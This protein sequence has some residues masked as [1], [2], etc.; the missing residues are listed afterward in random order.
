MTQATA[1]KQRQALEE[2]E[3]RLKAEREELEI[4][5]ALAATYAKLNVVQKF[6]GHKL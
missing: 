6:I 5:T 2:Q 4:L 3:A 1:L